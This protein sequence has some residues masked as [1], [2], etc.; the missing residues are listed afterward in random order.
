MT[1]SILRTVLRGVIV[2]ALAFFVPKL[3]LGLFI[4]GFILRA[5]HC[6]GRGHRHQR[7]FYMADKIRNMSEEEYAE[8]KTNMGGGCCNNGYHRHGHCCGG[9]KYEDKECCKSKEETTR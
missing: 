3:L 5:F 8:F 7:M 6:C 1:R 9:S 2:G 4:L